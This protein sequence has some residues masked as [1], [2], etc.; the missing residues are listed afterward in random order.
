MKKRYQLIKVPTGEIMI[1]DGAHGKL[2]CLSLGDYGKEK[3][4]KA[5]FLGLDREIDGVPHGPMMPLERKWVITISSQYGCSMGCPYCDVS[6]VGPGINATLKDLID[7]VLECI[8]LHPE[9]KYTERLNIHFARMGEPTYNPNVLDAARWFYDH[10]RTDDE[11]KEIRHIHPVVSTMMPE[12]NQWLKVFIHTWMRIKNRLY[13]GEAGLQISI[14]STD[15]HQ[16]A[17]LFGGNALPLRKIADIMDGV[18][19]L[20][21]KIALNFALFEG[22]KIDP[23]VLL[24]Y[25]DPES[26]MVKITPMHKT[27]NAI[28]NR[29]E[30]PDGYSSYHS[31]K[32]VEASLK[33]AGFDVIVFVPSEEEDESRITCGNAILARNSR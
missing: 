11:G 19:V 15:T 16:R 29:L 25:F 5:D 18:H 10:L 21:R 17:F 8:H 32:E 4:I 1:L 12:K 33:S 22:A 9:V 31:Y 23:D 7:Q 20:G 2:E 27:S 28:S 13:G 26:Y 3:N 30:T 14:N 6:T 24:D